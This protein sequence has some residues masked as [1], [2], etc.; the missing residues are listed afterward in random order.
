MLITHYAFLKKD[1]CEDKFERQI[2]QSY[3]DEILKFYAYVAFL[4]KHKVTLLM[5]WRPQVKCGFLMLPIHSI[6]FYLQGLIVIQRPD[7]FPAAL[8]I[9]FGL[10]MLAS[11]ESRLKHPS[12]WE[13]CKTFWYYLRVLLLGSSKRNGLKSRVDK[14]QNVK[15]VE[16]YEMKWDT[17]VRN[18][19]KLQ[20][21][22][23]EVK[24]KI[25]K[26]IGDEDIHTPSKSINLE[27]ALLKS[28]GNF[29]CLLGSEYSF[30]Y[31]FKSFSNLF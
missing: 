20:K 2:L 6:V 17:T 1:G 23:R 29:Q 13:K 18:N 28:L 21:K 15:E 26:E 9:S 10:L 30:F 25:K 7:L 19:Q 5:F 4:M 16:D 11:M 3:V 22:V 14:N 24:S 12:P 8:F 31:L 27:I